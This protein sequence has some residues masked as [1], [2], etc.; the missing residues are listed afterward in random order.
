MGNKD[1]TRDETAATPSKE[2][3]DTALA[4]T[5]AQAVAEAFTKQKAEETK[6]ITETF[7]RQME[8]MQVQYE[9]LLKAS[10]AQNFPS[11][12]K[13][14][15]GSE[16]FRVMDPFDWTHD[17]NIYQRWQLWSM[18]ARLALDAMEGDNEKT[19]ISYLHHWLDGK[20]IDKIKGW[21]NSKILISQ[22]DYDALEE[23]E[24]IGKYSADKVESY[25][26]LVENIL[27]PRSNPLLAVEE[28]H[29]AKQGSMTSQDFYSH[30]LQ[31][32]K[33][34]QFPNQEA[35]GRAIRD[36]IFIGMNS[37]RARDKAINLMNE[38]G[39]VVT[40]EFLMNHL[41]VEDG[42]S[43]H[44]FLSQLNSSS[45]VNMVAY[46]RRQNKGKGNRGKQSSGRNM[47]QNKSRGQASSST[48]QP[49]RKPPGMEGKCMRC[50]KPDHLQGQKCAA[51]N[52]KC[53]E[54]HKIGHF[55]KVCQSKKRTRR[56][57]LAQ[58]VPQNENDT[59]I[60]E[61]GLVQPNPPLVGML[62]LI[63]HIGTTNGTQGKHL[64]FPIDVDV[65]GSYKDHLIVR[66]DTGADDMIIAGKDEMEHDRNFQAFM[67]KCM[68]NNLTLN[69]EK[70]QFKQKQVSFYGNSWSENGISPDPKKI[71]A[72][73]HMEFPPD[74]E[75]MRSFLGMINYLNRYSALSAHL[76][77]P[78]SSLTHQAADYKPEKTN[79]ENFQRLKMEISNTKA[80]PYFDTS[81]E[82]TLQTDASKKGL[83]ACLIQNGKV[84]CYASRLLTKTEQNYQN[85]EREALGTIWGMEKFHYF[86]YGKEFTLETDQKP[87]VSIYKKHM[88]DISP[89]VQRLIVRSFPYQPFTVV[90]KKGRDIPVADALSRVTPM[91][92]EDNIKLPII[93]V[94][95]ITKLVLMS[96]FTQDN[97][98]RKLDR[99]R[100]STSQ[101]NQLTRLSHYINTG[102]PCEKKNLPRDL[103]DYWNYR[104]TL[105]I[106][107]GLIT[108]GSRIIVPH[109]M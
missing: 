91:D 93:A 72:L 23:R 28:L 65:R 79:M 19:K 84:V 53:K 76:A 104:D 29:V 34:C 88:V 60:D 100:K 87:L 49:S 20:G 80:L 69:A 101:D 57:N 92:P 6:L 38:E 24:R 39:K 25:F 70:I 94:N 54:C 62:K 48:A 32:V 96:T 15:S 3:R 99:I 5:I 45:S 33:R 107:N 26:S 41:A 30:V 1:K 2:S 36:A 89:R 43:Q 47:A 10:H 74:K 42:N 105:S 44:K 83:G 9:E 103:Q 13:V 109:E 59:H 4:R 81:A 98:S 46:D 35:E 78:L 8:K 67:E 22:Q 106:E 40:V 95:M 73:K 108:C 102:F 52:A 86:L 51:K 37:Q 27:T 77:A 31:I 55:Y 17:K 58:A 71:Q 82:T 18:K 75:T 68:E 90:Y 7:T 63:N 66:V 11:T 14:T 85:L 21:M 56:A 16:G 50:G 12:L 61:C 64:K 97:F